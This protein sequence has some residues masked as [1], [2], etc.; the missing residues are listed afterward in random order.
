MERLLALED[1][2]LVEEEGEAAQ[3]AGQG[4]GALMV[5]AGAP[6]VIPAALALIEGVAPLVEAL[7]DVDMRLKQYTVEHSWARSG[8][9]SRLA[10][11][12]HVLSVTCSSFLTS[13]LTRLENKPP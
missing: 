1:P 3:Q 12:T 2:P 9:A 7:A 8:P 10:R 5:A 4:G 11:G 6:G 13:S